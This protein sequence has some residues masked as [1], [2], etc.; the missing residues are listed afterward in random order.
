MPL[1]G[2]LLIFR[3]GN[4]LVAPAAVDVWKA[5]TASGT[6]PQA[7]SPGLLVLQLAVVLAMCVGFQPLA[8][9]AN[10]PAA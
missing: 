10:D 8:R 5:A 6:G 1:L 9:P 7:F 4:K 3:Y 2:L